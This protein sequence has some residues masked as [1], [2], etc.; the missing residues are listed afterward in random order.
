MATESEESIECVMSKTILLRPSDDN[1]GDSSF[2]LVFTCEK[3]HQIVGDSNSWVC[4]NKVLRAITLM[5]TKF[6][7][8]CLCLWPIY[9]LVML[10]CTRTQKV[11]FIM[12]K[13]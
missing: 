8:F 3:C 6:P 5:R 12:A 2:P 1:F 9:S 4:T 10:Q 11:Y 13:I 7:L